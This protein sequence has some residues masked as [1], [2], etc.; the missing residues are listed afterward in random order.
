M[1]TRSSSPFAH[2]PLQV[3]CG[4]HRSGPRLPR[5]V[6]IISASSL[7]D[8]EW[9]YRRNRFIQQHKEQSHQ[10]Q[11]QKNASSEFNENQHTLE[12]ID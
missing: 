5:T 3:G 1:E 12:K 9:E 4:S 10:F 6:Q 7:K 11:E 2:L 8:G